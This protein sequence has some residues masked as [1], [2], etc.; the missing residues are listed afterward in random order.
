MPPPV[1]VGAGH[2]S[3]TLASGETMVTGGYLTSEGKREFQLVKATLIPGE[4]GPAVKMEISVLALDQ[5][6]VSKTGLDS[7][8]TDRVTTEQHGEIWSADEA[9][10]FMKGLDS[11]D[12]LSAPTVTTLPGREFS[13][14]IGRDTGES[15]RMGGTVEILADGNLEVKLSNRRMEAGK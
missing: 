7:L 11:G 6:A 1:L 15:F 2:V 4:G 10:G 5:K 8:L 3:T 9:A 14:E 12:R 13:V